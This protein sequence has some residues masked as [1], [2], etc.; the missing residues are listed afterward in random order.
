M[1]KTSLEIEQEFMRSLKSTTGKDIKG[2]LTEIKKSG[3]DKRNDIINWLK[4]KHNFGHLH[5]SL[6]TGIYANGGKPVYGNR[7]LGWRS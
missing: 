6:L 3:K 2:W 1:A 7:S 4:E 5:A